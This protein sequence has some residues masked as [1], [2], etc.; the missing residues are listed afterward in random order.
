MSQYDRTIVSVD[1]SVDFYDKLMSSV[2]INQYTVIFILKNSPVFN[3]SVRIVGVN[4]RLAVK[5]IIETSLLNRCYKCVLLLH[6]NSLPCG[7]E[8]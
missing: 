3:L 2:C 5:M 1:N 7:T 4:H 6:Y 8:C